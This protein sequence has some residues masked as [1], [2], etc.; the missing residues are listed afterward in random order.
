MWTKEG[1]CGGKRQRV[2]VLCLTHLQPMQALFLIG[3]PLLVRIVVTT[4]GSGLAKKASA[5]ERM[6]P[7]AG[8]GR[9]LGKAIRTVAGRYERAPTTRAEQLTLLEV[10]SHPHSSHYHRPRIGAD[11][12]AYHQTRGS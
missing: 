8:V 11:P 1:E 5:P 7:G 9:G 4:R 2:R 12:S 6:T 10:P 3:P